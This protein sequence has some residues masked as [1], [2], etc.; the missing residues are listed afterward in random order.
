MVELRVDCCQCSSI[1]DIPE[2][3]FILED[4]WG[5]FLRARLL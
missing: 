3:V 4:A 2:I 5:I 1:D